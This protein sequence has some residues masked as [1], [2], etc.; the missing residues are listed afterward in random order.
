MGLLYFIIGVFVGAIGT[1]IFSG[2]LTTLFR[3]DDPVFLELNM[4]KNFMEHKIDLNEK[5]N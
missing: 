2:R 1:G 4:I 3:P 5:Y